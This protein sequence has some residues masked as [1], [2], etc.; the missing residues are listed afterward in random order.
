[1]RKFLLVMFLSALANAAWAA[2]DEENKIIRVGGDYEVMSIKEKDGGFTI[3]FQAV[4]KTGKFDRLRL[5]SDHVHFAVKEG[6]KLRLSAEVVAA[7]KDIAEVSQVLL[8]L[9]HDQGA[10]PVWLLSR[11]AGSADLRSSRYLQMH[12]PQADYSVF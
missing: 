7:N 5:D 1:M 6:Q 12:A 11:Q 10:L 8:F 2:D 3:D 9:P 4:T